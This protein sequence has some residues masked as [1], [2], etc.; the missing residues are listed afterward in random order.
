MGSNS[1]IGELLDHYRGYLWAVANEELSPEL[2]RKI[3]PSDLVQEASYEATRSFSDF[4]GKSEQEL[5]AWLRKI[6]ICNLRD[7]EK[8]FRQA[9]MRDCSRETYIHGSA[10]ESGA[11]VELVS[12]EP[13]PSHLIVAAELQQCLAEALQMLSEEQRRVVEL[14]SYSGLSFEEIGTAIGKSGEAARKIWTRAIEELSGK[15]VNDD[16]NQ[17]IP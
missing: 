1:A 17:W 15:V 12:Q 14:R 11:G 3:A 2:V 16:S 13:T 10:D 8:R 5:R 4:Q 6:L 7:A 9:L